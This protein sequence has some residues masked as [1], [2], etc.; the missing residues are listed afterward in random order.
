MESEKG[1]DFQ[2]WRLDLFLFVPNCIKRSARA[3]ENGK[4]SIR[5]G[6]ILE[7]RKVVQIYKNMY[8]KEKIH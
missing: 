2:K 7:T 3:S 1:S 6:Y 8:S 4:H 5:K